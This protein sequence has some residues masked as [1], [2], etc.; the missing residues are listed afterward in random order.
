MSWLVE[1][2]EERFQQELILQANHMAWKRARETRDQAR[3]A[4]DLAEEAI[5]MQM[6]P[7]SFF[8]AQSVHP[9]TARGRAGAHTRLARTGAR[10]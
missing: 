1:F 6:E 2:P 9:S 7:T 4:G 5:A 8:A 10:R 3:N